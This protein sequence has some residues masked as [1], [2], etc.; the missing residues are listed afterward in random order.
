MLLNPLRRWLENPDVVLEGQVRPGDLA[1]DVGCAMG[2]FT[3]PLAERVG[4]EG[5]VIGVDLQPAMLEGLRKRASRHGLL[6]RI[7]LRECAPDSLPLDDLTGKVDV[8]L[9][10][11]MV[12]EVPDASALFRQLGAAMK[13]GGRV[14]FAEPLGHVSRAAFDRTLALASQTGL[15]VDGHLPVRWGRGRLLRKMAL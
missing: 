12:H 1:V 9:I 3:L 10:M 15:E 14:L 11:H 7:D 5:R 4:S 2:Y 13:P 6:A 8:A